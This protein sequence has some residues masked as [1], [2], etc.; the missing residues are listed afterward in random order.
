MPYKVELHPQVPW[1][2]RTA[3]VPNFPDRPIDIIAGHP[4]MESKIL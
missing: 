1:Y 2:A 4:N 3:I